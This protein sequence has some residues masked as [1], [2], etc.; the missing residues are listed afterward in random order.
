[1]RILSINTNVAGWDR[2]SALVGEMADD[3]S[4]TWG[5]IQLGLTR[6]PE[7]AE[8]ALRLAV[9]S[10]MTQAQANLILKVVSARH[11]ELA[12][13]YALRYQTRFFTPEMD[14]A[15]R[16]TVLT[17]L[18]TASS[19]AAYAGKLRHYAAANPVADMQ[20]ALDA[21]VAGIEHR[22]AFNKRLAPQ[23]ATW[24]ESIGY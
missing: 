1:M 22:A 10:K 8:R 13:D 17:E 20:E 23:L 6:S 3:E 15:A 5:Y 2:M 19:D 9:L 14:A 18:L 24:L 11:P 21:A 16:I 7:L 12:F 4:A